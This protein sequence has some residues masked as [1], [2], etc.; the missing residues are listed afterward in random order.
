M[1][2]D[3]AGQLGIPSYGYVGW[4]HGGIYLR[5]APSVGYTGEYTFVRLRWLATPGN[6]PAA[7]CGRRSC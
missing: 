1:L 5:T 3:A 6:I 7:R 4:L 2:S